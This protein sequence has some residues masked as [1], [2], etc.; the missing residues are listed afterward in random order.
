MLPSIDFVKTLINAV[1]TRVQSVKKTADLAVSTKAQTL[2]TTQKETARI[3]ISA[4]SADSVEIYTV[5]ASHLPGNKIS[6]DKDLADIEA[7]I[8]RGARVRLKHEAYYY[9]YLGGMPGQY[10]YFG[11]GLNT[12]TF[13]VTDGRVGTIR[14]PYLLWMQNDKGEI[15]RL[16][17]TGT[18][19]NVDKYTS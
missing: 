9:P 12:P 3:N 15:V 17:V 11:G 8:A 4:A 13:R 7:A 1:M 2:T 19:L 10:V 6:T 16:S 5:F 14:Y 18:T